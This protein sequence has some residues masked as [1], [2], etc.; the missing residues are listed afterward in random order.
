MDDGSQNVIR[1]PALRIRLERRIG[2]WRYM[3]DY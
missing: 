3:M 2:A 1:T